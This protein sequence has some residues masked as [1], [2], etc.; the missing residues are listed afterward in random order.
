MNAVVVV[1]RLT[2][3]VKLSETKTNRKSHSDS[4][5]EKGNENN[6]AK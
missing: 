3:I 6:V 2:R 4:K 1:V 5:P